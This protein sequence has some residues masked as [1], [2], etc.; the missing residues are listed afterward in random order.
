MPALAYQYDPTSEDDC[1]AGRCQCVEKVI[2]EM[3]CR[4]DPLAERCDHDAVLAM[5]YLRTTEAYLTYAQ[6]SDFFMDARFVNHQDV[7]FARMYFDAYDSWPLGASKACRQ[8]GGSRSP[9]GR[10]AGERRR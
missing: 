4:F 6:R 9:R 8:R 3:R 7:V 5:A 10:R 1:V 2:K